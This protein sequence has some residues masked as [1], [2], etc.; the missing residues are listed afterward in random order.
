MTLP[1]LTDAARGVGY[2][3][4]Q[5]DRD[6]IFRR[7]PLL[8]RIA[9]G[10]YPSFALMVVC[11]YL[12]V[13]PAHVQIKNKALILKSAQ[14]PKTGQ[15]RDIVIPIDKHGSMRINF[16]GPWGR[17]KHYNFS[18][19][20]D[21]SEDRDEMELWREELASKIV[22]VSDVST[23]STD[24]GKI[25]GD[26]NFPLSGI[27]ANAV[28]TILTESF[29]KV[30]TRL[31][32]LGVE[33]LLLLAAAMLA[34]H[35]S[36][37]VF[38]LGTFGVAAGY[39]ATVGLAIIYGSFLLPTVRPLLM[40][41][42]TLISLQ[43]ASAI[44]NTRTHAETEKAREIVERELE[45]GRR[46]QSGFFPMQLPAAP[47]WDIAAYF[48]PAR[49][50]A[51]DFYDAFELREGQYIGI[52]I[53]DVCDKGVGAALFMALIRSLIRAFALRNFAAAERPDGCN[54]YT[55]N[56]AL[57]NTVQQTNDYLA[58][59]HDDANMFATLFMGI[60][61]PENAS[62]RYVNGGHEPPLVVSETGIRARLKRTGPAVGMMPDMSY[63]VE[64]VHISRGDLLFLYTDGLT[65]AQSEEG[66]LFGRE[67]LTQ[68]INGSFDTADAF[69]QGVNQ[70][71]NRHM[72]P[73]AQFDDITLVAVR[74]KLEI[75]S[76]K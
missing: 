54:R 31:Q 14:F 52:V 23:G 50:V 25:P 48:K 44:A 74:R 63:A 12:Q 75:G 29:F 24:V 19:V 71:L 18:D 21:A 33:L 30:P 35:R 26:N 66:V 5:P 32:T 6:G 46:I 45:I 39:L 49:Q 8:V 38:T 55:A 9:D 27:H 56:D 3:N 36:A 1:M 60:I 76:K 2:L 34:F 70:R 47:G 13:P 57:Q 64:E 20:H 62:M 67:R 28:H 72:G 51:G 40:L 10:F 68:V 11:D 43:I 17:M 42:F 73:A 58:N 7:L 4:I 15:K 16:V 37:V 41:F 65:D 53:A 59:T 61:D 69:I 22:L